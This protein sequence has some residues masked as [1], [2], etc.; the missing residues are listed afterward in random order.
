M[1][2][3][4]AYDECP[5]CSWTTLVWVPAASRKLAAECRR[6]FRVMR[7]GR[8]AFLLL[9]HVCELI[10]I[11]AEWTILVVPEQRHEEGLPLTIRTE[12]SVRD[13]QVGRHH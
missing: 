12:P 2:A 3:V 7:G 13:Q 9:K 10:P 4:M 1:S 8:L 6:V 11:R 5:R